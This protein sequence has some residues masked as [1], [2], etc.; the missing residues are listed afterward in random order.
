MLFR[1][2]VFQKASGEKRK[3]I[4]EDYFSARGRGAKLKAL[5]K[6]LMSHQSTKERKNHYQ[7]IYKQLFQHDKPQHI[8]D[9]GCGL[10]PM[11]Y[12]WLPNK[13]RYDCCDLS[14][15]DM[16][17]IQEFFAHE[18]IDGN[19]SACDLLKPATRK[20]LAATK[21]D[22]ALLL[23]LIDTLES[24]ERNVTKD[25]ITT[26]IQNS[27]IRRII[28]SFPQKSIG[29]R[30]FRKGNQENWFTRFLTEKSIGYDRAE[31]GDEEFYDRKR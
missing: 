13:P 28:I 31:G 7:D 26:L 24:Q 21:A 9:L 11:A 20:K 12:G 14:E 25:L 19:A 8:I 29:G 1:S 22:T 16:A 30:T 6:L 18:G 15:Q 23:K 5:D 27:N 4:L 3:A 10:N 2:G 17:L